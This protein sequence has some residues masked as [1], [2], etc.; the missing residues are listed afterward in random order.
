M[1]KIKTAL[2]VDDD[3]AFR[4]TLQ[5]SLRRRGVTTRT[6]ATIEEGLYS[7][8]DGPDDLVVLDYRLRSADGLAALPHFRR[9]CPEGVL[10]MLTGF[11]DIPLAVEAV[12]AGADT[13]LTKPIDP[14]RL[15]KVASE[16]RTDV[17]A[18][19][20][21]RAATFNL[22]DVERD[23]IRAALRETAGNVARAAQLLGIDRR[24]LQRKMK[25]IF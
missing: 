21:V 2:I 4:T 8:E 6:A 22:D 15:L 5:S 11:G 24:T 14:E 3:D 9:A 18:A 1:R 13:L 19:P 16:V 7:L 17:S 12:K 23:A 10:I 25:R 20:P